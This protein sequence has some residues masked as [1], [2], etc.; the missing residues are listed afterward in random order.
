[1]DNLKGS[2]D[3]VEGFFRILQFGIPGGVL[4][5]MSWEERPGYEIPSWILGPGVW[6]F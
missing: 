1:V 2:G 5:T 6:D 3:V 4:E